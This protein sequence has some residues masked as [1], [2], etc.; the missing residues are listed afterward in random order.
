MPTITLEKFR[1]R[2][3]PSVRLPGHGFWFGN[4][5]RRRRWPHARQADCR[6]GGNMRGPAALSVSSRVSSTKNNS[7]SDEK[8]K[9]HNNNERRRGKKHEKCH[10][11]HGVWIHGLF[12][13]RILE[14]LLAFCPFTS[15]EL[16]SSITLLV[17]WPFRSTAGFCNGSDVLLR[18]VLQ[19]FLFFSRRR[20]M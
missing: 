16:A 9:N 20:T 1:D 17:R 10:G 6:P 7:S 8:K 12:L 3:P 13:W 18:R 15:G 19:V 5:R 14:N 11:L 2:R 4:T